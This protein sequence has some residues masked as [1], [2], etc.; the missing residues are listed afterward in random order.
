VVAMGQSAAVIPPSGNVSTASGT[1]F[2]SP[3]LCGMVAGYWQANPTLTAIQVMDNVR[4]SGSQAD[5]PDKILGYGIPM[6]FKALANQEEVLLF[7]KVYPN[8]A[9]AE[10]T[11]EINDFNGK[12]YEASFMD[13]AGRVYK[14]EIIKNRVQTISVEK[15][16]LG[17]YFLRV[18]NEEKSSLVKLIKE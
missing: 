14:N 5:K 3:I 16:P 2:S 1:S 8:P 7:Y 10:I 4:K 15:M 6:L 17:I 13:V 18:G 11:V 12:N 9:K